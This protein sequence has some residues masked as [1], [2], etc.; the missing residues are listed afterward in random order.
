MS[1]QRLLANLSPPEFVRDFFLKQPFSQRGTAAGLRELGTWDA[2]REI[3]T[4]DAADF[5]LVRQGQLWTEATRPGFEQIRELHADGHT[6]VIKHAEQHH[7]GLRELARGF[8]EDF[9]AP[10]NIHVYCTPA[11]NFGFT[12]HYDAEDVFFIQTEGAKEYSLRKNTVNPWP[13]EETLPENMR[14]EREIMPLMRCQLEPGDWLYLPAGYWHMGKSAEPAITIAL[15]VM[16]PTGL[17]VLSLMQR[18][19]LDSLMWRQ[20][21]P[22]SGAAAGK[23][24]EELAAE[25]QEMIERLADDF[26]REALLPAVIRQLIERPETNGN[27]EP[28]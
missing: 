28:R 21:L 13:V 10:V 8:A 17:D 6:L 16:S 9:R 14:F 7:A 19:F 15:G 2:V 27:S 25:Y 26:R 23:S 24:T 22:A 4:D 18:R 12:W 11:E 20:R 3:L 1:L 5:M